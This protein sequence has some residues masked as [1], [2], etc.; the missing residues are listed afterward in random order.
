MPNFTELW[1]QEDAVTVADISPVSRM[2]HLQ[3]LG[4]QLNYGQGEQELG[5]R[6]LLSALQH[7]TQLRSLSLLGCKLR[8]A[9]PQQGHSYESFSALTASTQLTVLN[10]AGSEAEPIPHAALVHMFALG[11]VLPHLKVLS[12]SR[13]CYAPHCVEAA[14]VGRIAA[15]CPALQQL[16]LRHVTPEGFDV[17]CLAQL[18]PGVTAVWE[19]GWLRPTVGA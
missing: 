8:W 18:P 10:N 6:K 4:L 5:A 16:K 9:H 11:H 15:S 19:L 2:Q 3:H 12:L 1:Q 13:A 17:S 14:Q 7:L